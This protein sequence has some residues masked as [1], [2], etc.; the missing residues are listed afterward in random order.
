[1]KVNMYLKYSRTYLAKLSM[2]HKILK[3]LQN[4]SLSPFPHKI[5]SNIFLYYREWDLNNF[6]G[7]IEG[8]KLII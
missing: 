7:D 5:S 6:Q 4:C 1:M 2:S 3:L 8:K